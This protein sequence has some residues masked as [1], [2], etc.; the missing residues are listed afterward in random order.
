MERRKK[1]DKSL[2][3]RRGIL[4]LLGRLEREN[5]TVEEMEEIGT[6]L[7]E[8]GRRALSPL[9]RR[10]WRERNGK[11]ISK[12]AYLLD[13]FEDEAWLE[14]LIQM[15]LKRKDLEDEGKAALLAALEGYGVDVTSP[16]FSRLLA[17]VGRPLQVSLPRILDQ[18]DEG[19]AAFLDDILSYP[20]EG[21]LAVIGELATVSDPRVLNVL[22]VLVGIDDPEIVRGAITTLGRIR[23]SAAAAILQRLSRQSD[24]ELAGLAARNLRRL[25][26][27]GIVPAD[28]RP[29][30]SPLS[31]HAAYAG[32]VDGNG[33]R[34]LCV[35]GREE[36]GSFTLLYVQTHDQRGMQSASGESGLELE[37]ISRVLAELEY[38]ERVLAVSPAYVLRLLGDAVYRSRQNGMFLPV[39]YYL[40]QGMFASDTLIAAPYDPDFEE[41]GLERLTHSARHMGASAA[42]FEEECFA[43]WFLALPRVYDYAEEWQSLE[44]ASE[45]QLK[46]RALDN[47]LEKCCRE[48]FPPL[49]E[50]ISRRL[51]LTADLVRES[52]GERDL[53]EHILAVALSLSVSGFPCH[54]HPFLRRL[55]LESLQMARE[56]LGEG[57]DPRLYA[58]DDEW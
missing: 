50:Q 28:E 41:V 30:S 34:T 22:E 24:G 36:S 10:L 27:L 42:L 6:T 26:F 19:V 55:A 35:A 16:P 31:I 20:A 1:I 18:G 47:L 57:Y 23:S 13:F 7:R 14:Q 44:E 25:T 32:P 52:G 29:A 53:V 2:A 56:S 46:G 33:S 5:I 58:E 43:D 12:Y 4:H 3:E 8:A 39:D 49:L 17:E 38:E 40:R 51:L 15:V 11:L 48:I 9:V 54:C 21:R 45:K 37:E